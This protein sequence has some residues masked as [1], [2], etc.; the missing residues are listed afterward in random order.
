MTPVSPDDTTLIEDEAVQ[1]TQDLIR[2]DSTNYGDGTGPGERAAADHVVELLR[3]VGL[4]P[5]LIESEPGR[6]NV[7]VRLEG[8]D[9]SR[10]GLVLHGHLDVVPANAD[11]W[12]VDPFSGEIRDGMIWGRGAVDMK[13]MDAMILANVRHLARTGTKPPRDIVVAFFADEEAGGTYGAQWLVTHHPELFEGC[14]QSISEVGGYSITVPDKDTGE[15]VRA[16]LLQTAEKG[17]AWIRLRATGRAGHGSVP[18]DENAIVRLARAIDRIDAHPW[19]QEL[20]SSV[21]TLFD[22]ITAIT[23]IERDEENIEEFLPLL[24]GARQFV[25]GTLRDSANLTMLTAGYKNNVIPGSA[26]A[27]IDCRFLPGHQDLL[28]D[29]IRELAGEHVEVIIDKL[30]ISLDAPTSSELID[31]MRE[32]ILAEDPGAHLV[33]YCLSAG[34]D[35]KALKR[36]DIDGY[37]FAP[38][39]L[40]ADLDFAPLFHG[41]DERVPVDAVRFGARVL[42]RLLATC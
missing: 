22:S 16:Y 31:A 10:P 28:L 25:A 17:F 27:A 2:I 26:E 40:P 13:N 19:P 32:S 5:V 29:T 9:R 4:D 6:A 23:G 38:L 34:T 3:D 18:N 12:T 35:N 11:D 33:P 24:G 21:T 15:P 20:V 37:G 1:I 42:R 30:G 8:A 14:S 7:I 39:Q 41:V 36:L